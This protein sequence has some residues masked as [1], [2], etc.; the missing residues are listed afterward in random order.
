MLTLAARQIADGHRLDFVVQCGDR[1]RF[2]ADRA[3]AVTADR[4]LAEV[5]RQGVVG[6]EPAG[7]E[8][9]FAEEEFDRF[10]RLD[11]AEDAGEDADDAGLR[12]GGDGVL[13][14]GLG[15]TQR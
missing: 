8:L 6:E 11:G 10:G 5:H 12:T 14:G 9:P 15:K 2:P 4:Y 7:E 1:R 13:G 3:V